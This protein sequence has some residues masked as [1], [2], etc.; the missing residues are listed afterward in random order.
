MGKTKNY[1]RPE[2]TSSTPIRRELGLPKIPCIKTGNLRKWK[3]VKIA[4]VPSGIATILAF[5]LQFAE[6]EAVGKVLALA[7]LVLA[8]AAYV[9]MTWYYLAEV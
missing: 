5:G 2:P 1:K 4:L 8:L 7:I 3:G 9:I 6:D